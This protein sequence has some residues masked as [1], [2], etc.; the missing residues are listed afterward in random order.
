[1]SVEAHFLGENVTAA[2]FPQPVFG[3]STELIYHIGIQS[4]ARGQRWQEM[5][6]MGRGGR[7]GELNVSFYS[8]LSYFI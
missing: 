7:I 2:V 4:S 8:I 5:Q 3:H 1:M 6:F